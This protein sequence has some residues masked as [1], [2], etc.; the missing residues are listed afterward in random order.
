[1]IDEQANDLV[2]EY[3]T[4]KIKERVHDPW[5]ADKLIP[6]NHGKCSDVRELRWPHY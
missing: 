1:M 2:T 4:R 5:T 6:K 3:V